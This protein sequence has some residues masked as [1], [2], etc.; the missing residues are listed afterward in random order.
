M[1]ADATNDPPPS[2]CAWHDANYGTI[3]LTGGTDSESITCFE[4]ATQAIGGADIS[5][6]G[7]QAAAAAATPAGRLL[8]DG[9]FVG[10]TLSVFLKRGCEPNRARRLS[11]PR[12]PSRHAS[13][14]APS[15]PC[16]EYVAVAPLFPQSMNAA[17]SS[18]LR[19][20][21]DTPLAMQPARGSWTSSS[22]R[23]PRYLSSASPSG[24]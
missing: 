2:G 15:R 22:R 24:T 4:T 7:V 10:N 23:R 8:N 13:L 20:H 17:A 18:A 9:E 16:A 14:L 21:T 3:D 19:C 12:N 11:P 5:H 6:R 1:R